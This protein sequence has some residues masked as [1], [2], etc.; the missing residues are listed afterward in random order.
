LDA[1]LLVMADPVADLVREGEPA[2]ARALAGLAAV[3]P[4]LMVDRDEHSRDVESIV[5]LDDQ[6]EQIDGDR[7]DRNRQFVCVEVLVVALAQPR[8]DDAEACKV[9]ARASKRRRS[10]RPMSS[11]PRSRRWKYRLSFAR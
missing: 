6:P 5:L 8:S 11:A 9:A 10:T 3:E 4:D 7:L 2:A 1:S